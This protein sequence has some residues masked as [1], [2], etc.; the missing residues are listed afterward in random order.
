MLKG[1]DTS[2]YYADNH[3]KYKVEIE[4][5]QQF[6]IFTGNCVVTKKPHSVRISGIELLNYRL[7]QLNA[8]KSLSL[9][10]REFLISG[11]T[12][13]GWDLVFG[14]S[15]ECEIEITEDE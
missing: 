12:K 2:M 13:E 15:D 5:G 6:Y 10:D 7:G 8:F 1:R 11:H 3:C 4:N 9:D 14:S